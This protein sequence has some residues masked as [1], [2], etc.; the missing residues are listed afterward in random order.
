MKARDEAR[1]LWREALE[2]PSVRLDEATLALLTPGELRSLNAQ[3]IIDRRLASAFQEV[4]QVVGEPRSSSS[5]FRDNLLRAIRVGQPKQETYP[6]RLVWRERWAAFQDWFRFDGEAPYRW[7]PA[8][9]VLLLLPALPI[10]L[11]VKKEQQ[12]AVTEEVAM[13]PTGGL[14][15]SKVA[16]APKQQARPT[17]RRAAPSNPAAGAQPRTEGETNL[18]AQPFY[19]M[20]NDAQKKA[21]SRS[22][23]AKPTEEAD[24]G[25]PAPAMER[26]APPAEEA[27][28]Q[29]E[30]ARA[31][32][33]AEK[34]NI[35]SKLEALYQKAG[36]TEKL[37]KV[38]AQLRAL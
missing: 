9:I 24:A 38:R 28:L 7:A 36:A 21:R 30:L 20:P 27:S 32:T 31:K 22:M 10:L 23:E 11:N 4:R 34:R 29:A 33:T 14:A 13:A 17:P 3:R 16:E 25:K 5:D 26:A 8:L 18:S 12:T 35:L 2:D 1:R 15:E 19:D 6:D 37:S